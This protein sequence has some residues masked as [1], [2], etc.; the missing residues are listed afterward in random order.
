MVTQSGFS[1]AYLMDSKSWIQRYAPSI[2]S[3]VRSFVS[4]KAFHGSIDTKS[5]LLHGF[6]DGYE[7]ESKLLELHG[8]EGWF[9]EGFEDG[10]TSMDSNQGL[11]GWIRT[12]VSWNGFEPMHGLWIRS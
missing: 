2:R 6:E 8:F 7:L 4:V 5:S 12:K 1:R 3:H 11:M 10:N 9:F